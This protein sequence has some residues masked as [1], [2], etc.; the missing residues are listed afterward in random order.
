MAAGCQ[1]RRQ[2]VHTA[3]CPY[4]LLSWRRWYNQY[5]NRRSNSSF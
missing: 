2:F 3:G 1:G 4:Y 5:S